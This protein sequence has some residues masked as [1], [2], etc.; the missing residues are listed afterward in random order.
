MLTDTD[1]TAP[2][3]QRA[4]KGG[5][6]KGIG[7]IGHSFQF[8][9]PLGNHVVTFLTSVIAFLPLPFCGRVKISRE[10]IA[11]TKCKS[12]QPQ[13]SNTL[14]PG[15][16]RAHLMNYCHT[17]FLLWNKPRLFADPHMSCLIFCRN[18]SYGDVLLRCSSEGVPP[19]LW[20]RRANN[21]PHLVLSKLLDTL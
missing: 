11:D 1:Q 6:K 13:R 8:R 4:A 5:R 10:Q 17:R 2:T 18:E 9:S 21:S 12:S 7:P 20:S 19:H 16:D 3:Y 14:S 15:R